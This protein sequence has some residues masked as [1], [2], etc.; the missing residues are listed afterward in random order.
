[1]QK[2]IILNA[3]PRKS[4]N[5]ADMVKIVSDE[6][7][8]QGLEVEVISLAGRSIQACIAC[9][10]CNSTGKCIIDDGANEIFAKIE[11][12]DG[13]IYASPVYFGTARGDLLN[14]L[15]RL[16]MYNFRHD[17]FLD[18]VVGGPIAVARRGGHTATIQQLLMFAFINGMTI[19]GSNYWNM[20]CGKKPGEA[21]ED[22]EGIAT[23]RQFATN[24][25]QTI[26]KTR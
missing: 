1:M 25:C 15:Q 24:V 19:C 3:S 20:V 22:V 21:M 8:A 12:A 23:L 2:I 17:R 13:L 4:G 14:L 18:G 26:K 10:E 11:Q 9:P 5:T 16:G 7:E 6:I